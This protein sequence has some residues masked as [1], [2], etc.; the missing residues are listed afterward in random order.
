[1]S[2]FREY[3]HI[4]RYGNDDVQG[5]ELGTCHVY[6]KIDGTN[7]SIWGIWDEGSLIL[8]GAGSRKRELSK[9]NDNAG[10]YNWVCQQE[11]LYKFF[12]SKI[13]WAWRLY[14][15]WLV[16]H[17]IK[18]YEDSAWRKFYVFDVYHDI[19]HRYLHYDEYKEYLDYYKID[20]IPPISIIKN[21]TYDN[22]LVELNNNNFL[23]PDGKGI[24]EGIVIK[25]YDYINKYKRTIWA[26]IVTNS[27][28]TFHVTDLV[29][30]KIVESL[31][32]K[33]FV[34]KTYAKIV[35]ENSGWN[36]KYIPML[37]GVVYHDLIKE[38]LWD[39]LK[40]YKSPIINFKILNA[41]VIKKIKELKPELF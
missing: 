12:S 25:N 2:L 41:L 26:K 17:T 28:K 29:E 23:I 21:A 33:A 5:I 36:S 14:G 7:G 37:F 32:D 34:D 30:E 9:E 31:V 38:E 24:G 18:T 15:E 27:F 4:E 3:M 20:Y 39:I 10:F 16:P 13:C 6:P 1:M 8:L 35:N 11:H 40:K 19:E 22:L